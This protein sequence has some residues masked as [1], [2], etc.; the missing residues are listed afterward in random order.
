MVGS[1]KFLKDSDQRVTR[2]SVEVVVVV[3]VVVVVIIIIIII[4]CN[5]ELINYSMTGP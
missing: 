1:E 4:I 5:R 2:V 3:V